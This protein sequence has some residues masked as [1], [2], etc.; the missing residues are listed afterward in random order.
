MIYGQTPY[1]RKELACKYLFKCGARGTSCQER[2][3]SQRKATAR[4]HLE[5][6]ANS[7]QKHTDKIRNGSVINCRQNTTPFPLS[8]IK[9]AAGWNYKLERKR[10]TSGQRDGSLNSIHLQLIAQ[11]T[12]KKQSL[13]FLWEHQSTRSIHNLSITKSRVIVINNPWHHTVFCRFTDIQEN[14]LHNSGCK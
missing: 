8:Q 7:V 5:T 12:R 9:M 2:H 10:L 4:D 14:S 3:I 6:K 11:V 13:V 1:Q